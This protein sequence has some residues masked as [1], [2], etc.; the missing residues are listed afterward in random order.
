MDSSHQSLLP[1]ECVEPSPYNGNTVHSC[2][3]TTPS[4][5]EDVD[6]SHQSLLPSECVE[7]SPYN[8][9]TSLKCSTL[10]SGKKQTQIERRRAFLLHQRALL[11]QRLEELDNVSASTIY[12][13]ILKNVNFMDSCSNS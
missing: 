1:S 6:S 8:G 13:Q 9:N 2:P 5:D 11:D 10:N 4:L 7:P 3:V 12:C